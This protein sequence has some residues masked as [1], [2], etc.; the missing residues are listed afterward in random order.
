[1]AELKAEKQAMKAALAEKQSALEKAEKSAKIQIAKQMLQANA[2]IAFI[3]QVTGL[4][5][6][7]I[8]SL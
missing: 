4:E 5:E 6:D 3:M 2:Q 7:L 8:K 1:V